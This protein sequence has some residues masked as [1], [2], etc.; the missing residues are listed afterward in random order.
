MSVTHQGDRVGVSDA[1]D[2]ADLWLARSLASLFEACECTLPE[3]E[4]ERFGAL[5]AE[6]PHGVVAPHED[7]GRRS[8][9][10]AAL[11]LET[12]LNHLLRMGGGDVRPDHAR[13]MVETSAKLCGL[14]E[15]LAGEP[16]SEAPWLVQHTAE[17]LQSRAHALVEGAQPDWYDEWDSPQ[18]PPN[19]VGS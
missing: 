1:V 16:E 19:L 14:L 13:T 10:F 3:E 15:H 9:V 18:F 4:R 12:R 5:G 6:L 17:R 2:Q 7:A 11:A 8:V